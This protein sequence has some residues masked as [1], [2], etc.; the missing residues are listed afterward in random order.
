MKYVF[1]LENKHPSSYD[2]V[3]ILKIA[4]KLLEMGKRIRVTIQEEI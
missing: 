2:L 1:T 4:I 3:K